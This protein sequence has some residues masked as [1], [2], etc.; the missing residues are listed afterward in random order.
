MP[1]PTSAFV[2]SKWEREQKRELL[3]WEFAR[4]VMRFQN[5]IY[6]LI[7]QNNYGWTTRACSSLVVLY[8][9]LR[10]WFRSWFHYFCHVPSN[11]YF[12][13]E[14]FQGQRP[15]VMSV[16]TVGSPVSGFLTS[17]TSRWEQTFLESRIQVYWYKIAQRR[18]LGR[19]W[20]DETG[21]GTED[22]TRGRLECFISLP[23]LVYGFSSFI[24]IFGGS[25]QGS[26]VW[27]G[28]NRVLDLRV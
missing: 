6:L 25:V 11:H 23:V 4:L 24:P 19:D 10:S 13:F 21:C 14:F 2:F 26:S 5:H 16:R 9:I 7:F 20:R 27:H 12:H 18:S 28:G 15:D 8:K 22:R 3:L 17:V 1:F